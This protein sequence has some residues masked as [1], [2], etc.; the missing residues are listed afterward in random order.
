MKGKGRS[1]HPVSH[2]SSQYLEGSVEV[3]LGWGNRWIWTLGSRADPDVAIQ[4]GHGTWAVCLVHK[5][6]KF[7]TITSCSYI[8][9]LVTCDGGNQG[10]LINKTPK[11]KTVIK[12]GISCSKASNVRSL[13]PRGEG[14]GQQPR[15]Y[16]GGTE[17]VVQTSRL[18]IQPWF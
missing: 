5:L 3:K 1:C 15:V 13:A 16:G 17:S 18:Q 12:R 11:G 2:I 7:V 4:C 8:T 6:A 9:I 14:R 10:R